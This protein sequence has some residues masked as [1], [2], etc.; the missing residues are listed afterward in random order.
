MAYG[1]A[2]ANVEFDAASCTII[3]V[4]LIII[5]FATVTTTFGCVGTSREWKTH[6]I[7]IAHHDTINDEDVYDDDDKG[8]AIR[9]II[10]FILI[11]ILIIVCTCTNASVLALQV[12]QVLHQAPL[13]WWM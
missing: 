9:I 4:T 1:A 11:H 12:Q 3:I 2:I 7:W 6:G 13:I 5:I 8:A 10:I